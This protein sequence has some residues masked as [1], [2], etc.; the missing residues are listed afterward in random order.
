MLIKTESPS[1]ADSAAADLKQ[2]NELSLQEG[3]ESWT[4]EQGRTEREQ[5]SIPPS[6][7]SISLN[8]SRKI[9]VFINRLLP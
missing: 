5:A 9:G 7:S 2:K 1:D 4:E 6:L 3:D 8:M